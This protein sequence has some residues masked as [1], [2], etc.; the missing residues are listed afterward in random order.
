MARL[1]KR[2]VACKADLGPGERRIVQVDGKSIGIFN[3]NGAYYAL[4]NRCPHMAGP[5]CQGPVT[6]T[7]RQTDRME[8]IYERPGEIVRCA[9]HG[10]EF[11]IRTGQCLALDKIRART[12]AVVVEN[13][14]VMVQIG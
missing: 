9:W 5:L 2:W 3:V 1:A 13:G 4:H 6:G 8:F 11:D 7:A 10:W 14:E 12:Y